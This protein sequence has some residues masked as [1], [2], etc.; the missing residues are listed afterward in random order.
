MLTPHSRIIELL[1]SDMFTEIT[2]TDELRLNSAIY[3]SLLK[4]NNI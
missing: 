3:K 4:I 1:G 2:F